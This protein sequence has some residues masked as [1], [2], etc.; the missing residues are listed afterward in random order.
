MYRAALGTAW[1]ARAAF[2]PASSLAHGVSCTDGVQVGC[3]IAELCDVIVG[4]EED[5][6]LGLGIAGAD[7]EKESKLDPSA[8]FGMIDNVKAKFPNVKVI[9]TTLREVHTTNRH[10]WSAVAWINGQ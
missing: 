3:R 5:L 4:N 6:Q 2:Q 10:T 7:V 1:T 9:A 8:F